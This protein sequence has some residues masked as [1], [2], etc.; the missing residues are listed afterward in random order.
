MF[1][2]IIE[3][4]GKIT[5]IQTING[6]KN[7]TLTRPTHFK[8]ILIGDSIAVNGVCLTVTNITPANFSV[9]LVPETLDKTNL[10]HLHINDIVNLERS[11]TLLQRISGH[12]V[13]G[14]VDG[15]ANILNLVP[16]RGEALLITFHL[17]TSLTRYVVQKGYITIDGM[18]MTILETGSDWFAVTLIP[19]TRKTTIAHTYQIGHIVNIEVDIIGK[20]V[21]QLIGVPNHAFL[22]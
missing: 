20:Y 19:H 10:G 13:Q 15:T 22:H 5:D 1:S 21:E 14:H 18:S 17:S 9:T 4:I 7:I 3:A 12:Y 11:I 6:C 8:D 16:D 2:G